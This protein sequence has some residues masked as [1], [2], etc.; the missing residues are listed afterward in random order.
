MFTLPSSW[1][2]WNTVKLD[3]KPQ[4]VHQWIVNFEMTHSVVFYTENNVLENYEV[5]SVKYELWS[6]NCEVWSL[7]YEVF[8][9]CIYI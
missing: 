7:N 2:D 5:W 3:V 9:I 8:R 6:M 4:I 1:Y